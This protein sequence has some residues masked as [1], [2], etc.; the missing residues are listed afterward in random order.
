MVCG[1]RLE[2]GAIFESDPRQSEVC[3]DNC[4]KIFTYDGLQDEIDRLKAENAALRAEV[5]WLRSVIAAWHVL[6]VHKDK[7]YER[8]RSENVGLRRKKKR[9]RKEIKGLLKNGK[10]LRGVIDIFCREQRWYRESIKDLACLYERLWEKSNKDIGHCLDRA[11]DV[12]VENMNEI[13]CIRAQL[14]KYKE[15]LKWYGDEGNYDLYPYGDAE[16]EDPVGFYIPVEDDKGQR[17]R[18]AVK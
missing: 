7:E 2:K 3:S 6:M 8:L 11:A 13:L 17:A 4:F 14:A 18:E 12:A 1:A 5:K 16:N 10:D 9:H 15:A